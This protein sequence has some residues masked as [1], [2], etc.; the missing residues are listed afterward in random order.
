M[1]DHTIQEMIAKNMEAE[2]EAIKEYIPLMDALKAVNDMDSLKAI[3]DIV[4]EEMKHSLMLTALLKKLD[5]NVMVEKE[6]ADD[7][8][9]YL[10]KHLVG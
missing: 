1:S 8:L 9:A 4:A 10:K 5:S 6:G 2:G 3:Q 7:A